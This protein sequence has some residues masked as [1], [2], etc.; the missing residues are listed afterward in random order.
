MADYFK[1]NPDAFDFK[2][3]SV[4][5]KATKFSDQFEGSFD[6]VADGFGIFQPRTNPMSVIPGQQGQPGLDIQN[7]YGTSSRSCSSG[8]LCL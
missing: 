8:I 7:W 5:D 6:Q 2:P 3:G 1:D 4:G